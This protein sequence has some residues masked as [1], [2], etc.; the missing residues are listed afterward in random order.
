[1]D[2]ESE[3]LSDATARETEEEIENDTDWDNS[4]IEY[5]PMFFEETSDPDSGYSTYNSY[6]TTE[7]SDV[8]SRMN[9]NQKLC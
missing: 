9:I 2:S 4:E 6:T 3:E 5:D 8:E 1:M 7:T